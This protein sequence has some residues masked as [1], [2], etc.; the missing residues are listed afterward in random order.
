MNF[1][2]VGTN[3]H[4]CYEYHRKE[5]YYP[6]DIKCYNQ[7]EHHRKYYYRPVY[8]LKRSSSSS[9]EDEYK[10]IHVNSVKYSNENII[11]KNAVTT[12]YHLFALLIA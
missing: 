12:N 5:I 7:V 6:A 11:Y 10:S 2:S 3:R 8:A 1:S 4:N 9:S